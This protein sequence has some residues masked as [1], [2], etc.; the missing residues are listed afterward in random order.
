MIENKIFSCKKIFA[1]IFSSKVNNDLL[2][3]NSID[4]IVYATYCLINSFSSIL[5][6][7]SGPDVASIV[8]SYISGMLCIF[9]LLHESW[10]ENFKKYLIPYW[11]ITVL[12]TLPLHSIFTVLNSSISMF[13]VINFL[14]SVSIL[15]LFTDWIRFLFIF[16]VGVL[17][18]SVLYTVQ[19]NLNILDFILLEGIVEML[20]MIVMVIFIKYIFF[21]K[22]QESY[23]KKLVNQ[24][25]LAFSIAHELR[26]PLAT[27]LGNIELLGKGKNKE[28]SNSKKIIQDI[29]SNISKC[30]ENI[31]SILY[32]IK[33]PNNIDLKT[34]NI[35]DLILTIIDSYPFSSSERA[36]VKV[37]VKRSKY[38]VMIN[39]LLF[40]QV[41]N[42]ILTN[43]LSSIK[44][45]KQ[46]DIFIVL[47]VKDKNAKIYVKDTGIGMSENVLKNLF[48]PFATDKNR[49]SGIGLA[50]SKLIIE[51]MQGK[52][53]CFSVEKKHTL[54]IIELPILL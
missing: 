49:G 35:A 19:C 40:T 1:F 4:Y 22:Q 8:L 21:K 33:E 11:Y 5:F 53:S 54:F 51:K 13:S 7:S 12:F 14:L 18:G 9:L 25:L 44:T 34:I 38:S 39:T 52:I 10:P 41:I 6:T 43:A 29:R 45:N 48:I 3:I 16:L 26:T 50:Y 47:K 31:S 17:L 30:H 24:K 15:S 27:L 23:V 32:S 2:T 42:N 37:N 46:G 36:C 28:K 20:Y